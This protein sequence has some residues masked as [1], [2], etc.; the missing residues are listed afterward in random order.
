MTYKIQLIGHN[1]WEEGHLQGQIEVGAIAFALI[2][3]FIVYKA[4]GPIRVR[5]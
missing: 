5:R 4:F 3:I 1:A 2:F